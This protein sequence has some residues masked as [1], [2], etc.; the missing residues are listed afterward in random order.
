MKHRILAL[1]LIAG[2]LAT[3]L[4]GCSGDTTPDDSNDVLTTGDDALSDDLATTV[5]FRPVD[6][7]IQAQE[8]YDYPFL[9]MTLCLP[10]ALRAQMDSREVF[11][12]TLEDYTPEGQIAYALLRFST[13]TEAQRAEEVMSIDIFAWEESLARLGAIGVYQAGQVAQLDTLTGCDTHTRIGQSA[14]GTYEY[15]LSTSSTA[16]ADSVSL[17]EQT[18]VTLELMH[19]LDLSLGYTAFSADRLEDVANVGAFQTTDIFGNSVTQEVFAQYDLTLVNVFATWCSPC[20]E[21]MPE[22][23]KLRQHYAEQGIRLGV[24][25]VV[26]DVN[27][28]SGTD[29]DALARAQALYSRAEAQFPFILPDAGNLNGRLVGIEAYPESFFVDSA[30]NLV[31]EPYVGANTLEGWMQIVEA[32]L[33]A[34]NG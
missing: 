4:V 15:Y 16:D 27:T 12:F 9:G 18:E 26:M 25:A 21:E 31:S 14:D 34:L 11:A 30:G 19:E 6:C 5:A 23:E 3:L 20:V 13:T 8:R 7:G 1:L 10:A 24:L 28:V 2:M 22:L 29:E 33:A 32:E 17:L